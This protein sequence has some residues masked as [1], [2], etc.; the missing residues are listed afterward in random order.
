MKLGSILPT[1]LPS[2]SEPGARGTDAGDL[3]RVFARMEEIADEKADAAKVV[4]TTVQAET[5][6]AVAEAELVDALNAEA[7]AIESDNHTRLTNLLLRYATYGTGAFVIGKLVFGGKHRT[8]KEP[9]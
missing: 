9:K 5:A 2:K 6:E 1:P 3:A 8:R 7:R 4:T